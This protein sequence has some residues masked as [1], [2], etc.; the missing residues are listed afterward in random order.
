M[1]TSIRRYSAVEC[2]GDGDGCED[3][4]TRRQ[5]MKRSRA[6]SACSDDTLVFS[7]CDRSELDRNSDR[8]IAIQTRLRSGNFLNMR[9]K[10]NSP[11][12]LSSSNSADACH[13][14]PQRA[15]NYCSLFSYL[16]IHMCISMWLNKQLGTI[17]P[18]EFLFFFFSKR[19]VES[20]RRR[21]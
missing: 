17:L 15:G 10:A 8:H 12:Y 21:K 6:L 18:I 11:S 20:K 13:T 9:N 2:D 16:Y 5:I 14:T 3:F 4:C 7:R 19:K 1:I